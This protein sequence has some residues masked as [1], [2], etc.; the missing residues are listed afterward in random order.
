MYG[1]K[2]L[3]LFCFLTLILFCLIKKGYENYIRKSFLTTI[4]LIFSIFLSIALVLKFKVTLFTILLI[5]ILVFFTHIFI[6]DSYELLIPYSSII[7]IFII[8]TLNLF[9]NDLSLNYASRLDRIVSFICFVFIWQVIS[10]IQN[11]IKIEFLGGGDLML[12]CV[13]S[14]MFGS[15]ATVLGIFI[16]SFIGL[17]FQLIRKNKDKMFPF[18]PYL[19]IGFTITILIFDYLIKLLN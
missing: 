13:V 14:L 4:V 12:F 2:T 6:V 3:I 11:K 18:G 7:G 9:C 5:F 15:L 10:I 1:D 16:A 8:A 19:V 17:V